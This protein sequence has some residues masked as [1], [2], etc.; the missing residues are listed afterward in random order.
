MNNADYPR[1][2]ARVPKETHA[3]IR[4]LCSEFVEADGKPATESAVLRAF[5]VA[6]EA[7]M[8]RGLRERARA[9]GKRMGHTSMA[10]TWRAVIE[11]GLRE[12]E[13]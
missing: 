13:R 10:E 7:L 6:G 9:V 2:F 12:M 5:I 8:D 1:V 3:M 4:A 11:A